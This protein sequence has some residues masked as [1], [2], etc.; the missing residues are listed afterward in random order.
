MNV[1]WQK[2]KIQNLETGP[3]DA[4]INVDGNNVDGVTDF[5]WATISSQNRH[6]TDI[7]NQT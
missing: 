5:T 4:S 3:L 6:R 1:S 2:T 7:A